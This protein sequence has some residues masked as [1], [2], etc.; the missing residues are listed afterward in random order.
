MPT[1]SFLIRFL[2]GVLV[3][4]S[5]STVPWFGCYASRIPWKSSSKR[6]FPALSTLCPERNSTFDIIPPPINFANQSLNYTIFSGRSALRD[7][8]PPPPPLLDEW[9]EERWNPPP[10]VKTNSTTSFKA[11]W[12]L[13]LLT[14]GHLD[15]AHEVLLGVTFDELE[16]AEYAATHRG[17]TTWNQDHPLDETD[18]FLH[19]MIHRLEGPQTGEGGYTGHENAKYWFAGGPKALSSLPSSSSEHPVYRALSEYASQVHPN[20]VR[21]PSST[22]SILPTL[23][24]AADVSHEIIAG[25]GRNRTVQVR[26]GSW[27]GIDLVDYW[28]HVSS[29][30]PNSN[31]SLELQLFDL[32][33]AEIL[34]WRHYL[35]QQQQ[36]RR[37]DSDSTTRRTA[38]LERHGKFDAA[39]Y[40]G[41]Q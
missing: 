20:L 25:G 19:S 41:S 23:I 21:R 33:C 26:A 39:S 32:H 8:P 2:T 15:A 17:Q 31:P 36:Q 14:A 7:L 28:D 3:A 1:I 38:F 5:I 24:P 13:E 22:S 12:A 11:I 6:T 4:T 16:A 18:D 34:L 30:S 35:Q 37:S 9:R 27:D 40:F 29:T 10:A